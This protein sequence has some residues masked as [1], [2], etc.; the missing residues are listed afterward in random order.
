MN[1]GI[2]MMGGD[3]APLEAVKGVQQYLAHSENNLFCIGEET[4]LKELFQT[5]G[6]SSPFLH[7]VPAT[8]VIGYHEHP[9]KALKEKPNP[10]IAIGFKLL[11]TGEIDAF[12]S[13][14]NTG[15]MLVGAMFSIKPIKG[16]LRPTIATLLPKLNGKTGLLVDVGLNADCKPEQLNQ[17]GILGN[18]YAKH[19][20]NIENPTVG[21]LNVGE[22]EGKGRGGGQGRRFRAQ[23]ARA[24]L[25][26]HKTRRQ[27]QSLFRVAQAPFGTAE[28]GHVRRGAV[29]WHGAGGQR[30]QSLGR[31]PM[32]QRE[33]LAQTLGQVNGGGSVAPTLLAGGQCQC[34]PMGL[35]LEG[36]VRVQAQNTALGHQ[37]HQTRH[38]QFGGF[39]DQPVHALI[40]GHAH[41]QHHVVAC[42]TFNGLVRK[43]V[44]RHLF[45]AHVFNLSRPFPACAI[46]QTHRV[47]GLQAHHLG[48]ACCG[49]GQRHTGLGDQGVGVKKA[50]HGVG[51]WWTGRQTRPKA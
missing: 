14:G 23:G 11:V 36:P 5:H 22:E 41:G 32:I 12:L 44:H 24:Q 1:I 51:Q 20:L 10:S 25:P 28:N 35:A 40:G 8:E 21:L 16:V 9:T 15:A 3:Y 2:D 46:E 50:G 48:V 31:G 42:F 7:I 38:T 18:L 19:I 43:D 17:F 4:Q 26:G 30:Q 29:D 33:K 13:A 45:A 49:R 37:W 47:A 34:L 6:I 39:F 27:S